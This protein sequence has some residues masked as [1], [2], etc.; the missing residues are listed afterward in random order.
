MNY[1]K[2][3]LTEK[4]IACVYAVSNALGNGFLEKVYHNALSHA[5]SKS[6]LLIEVEKEFKVLFDGVVVGDYFADIV[7]ENEVIVEV[8]AIQSLDNV[9]FA[10]CMN[11]LKS[12]GLKTCLL[13]NFGTPKV[14]IKRISN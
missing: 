9:H 8:K 11:Y 7:T 4:I 12:S 6:G 10:Q 3:E 2:D 13:V 1:Q 5:L 14:Q